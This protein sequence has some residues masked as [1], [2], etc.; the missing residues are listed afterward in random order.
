MNVAVVIVTYNRQGLLKEC[1]EYAMNQKGVNTELFI[2]NNASTDYTTEYLNE[3]EI[4]NPQ[5]HIK[6][7]E[8][9]IGGA[10]GFSEGLKFAFEESDADMFLLIDDD[11]MLAEDY[12]ENILR[13]SK[14][15]YLA[16]A[17]TVCVNGRVDTSHR[18]L[19][20]E[21]IL[22]ERYQSEKTFECTIA[23]FCGL[24]VTREIVN[25][26]GYPKSEFFIWNDDTEYSYRIG[27]YTKILNVTSAVINHKTS[28]SSEDTTAMKD[29][30][31]EYYGMR[32]IIAIYKEYQMYE[33]LVKKVV[34]CIGKALFFKCKALID[35]GNKDI[36]IFNACLRIDAVRD[37]LL[38]QM[39][40]NTKYIS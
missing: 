35:C 25:K 4:V 34:K 17:G 19:Y 30:W 31:K 6:H 3:L 40:K 16:Y 11:A 14:A 13:F 21:R 20:E 33:K 9:N 29:S 12:I 28:V 32:N 7:M 36:Y 26:I 24:L 38:G 37:G 1:I 27:K 15:E 8:S 39:G 5:I 23:T 2:V 10:G 22:E 18:L